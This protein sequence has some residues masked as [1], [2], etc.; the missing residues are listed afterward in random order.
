[1]ISIYCLGTTELHLQNIYHDPGEVIVLGTWMVSLRRYDFLLIFF[2]NITELFRV[3]G[4][5][6]SKAVQ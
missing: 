4:G 6:S 2:F 3:G 1:M 5:G